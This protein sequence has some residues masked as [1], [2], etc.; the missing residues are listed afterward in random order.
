MASRILFIVPYPLKES[1]SQRFR[2]EQYFKIL[3]NAGFEFET[4][5]FL[6]SQNWQVFF[7]PGNLKTKV[8]ALIKGFAK[9]VLIILKAPKYDFV[10]IHREATPAGPPWF[11]WFI[12]C[13]LRK[14][15]LYDFDDA[16]W[17]T[18]RTDESRLLRWMKWRSKV[19]SL[20]K[21]SYKVS[22]GN[23]Y[24]QQYALQ[25][26]KNSFINPTTIDI[27]YVECKAN[28]QARVERNNGLTIGWTGS[29]STLKYLNQLNNVFVQL[30]AQ[31]PHLN[32]T[33]IAN[34][35]PDL[36]FKFTFLHWNVLTEV[37]DLLSFDIGIMPLPDDEWSKGKCGF[38]ILQYMALGIPSVASPVGVNT[39][40]IQDGLN[41]FL[42]RD[43][44]E[45][46]QKLTKLVE[47]PKLRLQLSAAGHRT[48]LE[49]YSVRSNTSNFL[50]LFE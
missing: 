24:L 9:R 38:K 45:W 33:I 48:V 27:D 4:Q 18:D 23:Q 16:I 41:G 22:C 5:S 31:H 17:S 50:K 25:F 40:I 36:N 39:Q 2:F 42:C 30:L 8:W 19:E 14:K 13:V 6:D 47:D 26:N 46:Y 1:P 28:A 15:I 44:S 49:N 20:C 7:K 37:E 12:A 34:K 11:E 3:E 43:K 10:F 21:W 29:H 35:K 32:F